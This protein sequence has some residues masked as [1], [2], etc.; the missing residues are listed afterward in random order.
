MMPTLARTHDA[1]V[2]G[3]QCW[4]LSMNVFNQARLKCH[5]VCEA[6][7]GC[8]NCDEATNE[9]IFTPWLQ[10]LIRIFTMLKPAQEGGAFA[11]IFGAGRL[12][13]EPSAALHPKSQMEGCLEALEY[14]RLQ[15]RA[16]L[17]V[18]VSVMGSSTA[19][20]SFFTRLASVKL[21]EK[22]EQ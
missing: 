17:P 6:Q 7:T 20:A 11:F 12:R 5:S 16:T 1:H 8:L 3:T 4:V 13:E 21:K 14:Q 9:Q 22:T 18:C 10:T 19:H 2:L 15:Q